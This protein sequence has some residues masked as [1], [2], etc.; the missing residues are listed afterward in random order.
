MD[1]LGWDSRSLGSCHQLSHG[2][3]QNTRQTEMQP[4]GMGRVIGKSG[5]YVKEIRVQSVQYGL[6]SRYGSKAVGENDC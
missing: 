3:Y 6:P 1:G 5:S 4:K 2:R